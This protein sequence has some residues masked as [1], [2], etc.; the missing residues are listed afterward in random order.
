MIQTGPQ[1]GSEHTTEIMNPT[2]LQKDKSEKMRM[3][4]TE[5]EMEGVTEGI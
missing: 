4:Q 1:E 5:G 3:N 2:D